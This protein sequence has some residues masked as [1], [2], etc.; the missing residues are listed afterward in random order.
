[1]NSKYFK[2]KITKWVGKGGGGGLV[3]FW[4]FCDFLNI[5]NGR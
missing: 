1:M 4:M 2:W 5:L 3:V